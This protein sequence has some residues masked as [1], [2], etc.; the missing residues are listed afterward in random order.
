MCGSVFSVG[1]CLARSISAWRTVP[2][3]LDVAL[4]C[5]SKMSSSVPSAPAMASWIATEQRV[6]STALPN[7]ASMRP[8][9][10]DDTAPVFRRS[11]IDQAG[12]MILEPS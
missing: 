8:G 10:L 7:S 1:R 12:A 11:W 4:S 6:A 2:D 3:T 5:G 9:G